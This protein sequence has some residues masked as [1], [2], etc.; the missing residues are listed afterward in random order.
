MEKMGDLAD[1][2]AERGEPRGLRAG[3]PRGLVP[4]DNTIPTRQ[5]HMALSHTS[6]QVLK[7]L[8]ADL[9]GSKATSHS[10]NVPK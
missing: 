7:K 1:L 5:T 3:L 2:R 10:I 4:A 6:R 9:P 8:V